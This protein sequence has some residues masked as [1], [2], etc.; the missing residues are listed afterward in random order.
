VIGDALHLHVA[1]VLTIDDVA[2]Y[3]GHFQVLRRGELFEDVLQLTL[4]Y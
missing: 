4:P 3:A 1:L 2:N